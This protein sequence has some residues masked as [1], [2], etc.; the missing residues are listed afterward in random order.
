VKCSPGH[1]GTPPGRQ[2]VSLT[3]KRS[4]VQILYRPPQVTATIR[5]TSEAG[6]TTREPF[7]FRPGPFQ[8]TAARRGLSEDSIYYD[9]KASCRDP[10]EHRRCSGSW[11]G[12]VSLG[13]GPHSKG[14][15]GGWFVALAA[16]DGLAARLGEQLGRIAA[17]PDVAAWPLANRRD[18][19]VPGRSALSFL[20]PRIGRS[21]CPGSRPSI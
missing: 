1:S 15:D 16:D 21:A 9:H 10:E 4:Q 3:R 17:S 7:G 5:K 19:V 13:Y 11:L 8:A 6:D 14:R 12:V 20:P 2:R 18:G